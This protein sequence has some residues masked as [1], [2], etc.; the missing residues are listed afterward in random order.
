MPLLN[1]AGAVMVAIVFRGTAMRRLLVCVL[2]IASLGSARAADDY[3]DVEPAPA[4]GD[5]PGVWT[6]HFR[7]KPPRIVTV[8]F[9]LTVPLSVTVTM[10]PPAEPLISTSAS[11]AC[12][13][14]IRSCSFS[15]S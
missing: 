3:R 10:P 15:L 1:R 4:P 12:I 8:E 6:L 2:L 9:A 5:K 7:Y 11:L 14:A 13:S